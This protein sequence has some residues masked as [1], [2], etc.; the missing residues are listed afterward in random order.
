MS[1]LVI[2]NYDSF[3]YNIVQY[4]QE[5]GA[6]VIVKRNDEVNA[7]FIRRMQPEGIV[8]SPGPGTPDKAGQIESLILEFAGELPIFGVCL[9]MQAIG[10]AFGGKITRAKKIMHGKASKIHHS[11]EGAF[12]SLPNEF[13][14]IRYHSLVIEQASLPDCLQVT[15]TSDDGEIMGVRHKTHNVEGVQFHPESALSEHGK[16]LL[17]NWLASTNPRFGETSKERP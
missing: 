10:E 7:E 13:E 9:G 5:L 14:A 2:D 6:D 16:M 3:T 1:Y 15:A 17:K 12:R 8:L 11:G 4:M